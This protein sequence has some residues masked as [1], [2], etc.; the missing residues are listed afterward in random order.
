MGWMFS[1]KE[2][3]EICC[4]EDRKLGPLETIKFWMH[5]GVCK[6]CHAYKKQVEFMSATMKKLFKERSEV[7]EKKVSN[8]EKEII[9]KL[10]KET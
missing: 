6:A 7:D 9:D 8:L 3:T 5:L 4:D 1:C 10:V 2:V